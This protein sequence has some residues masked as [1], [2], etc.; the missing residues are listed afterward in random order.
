MEKKKKKGGV[1]VLGK[2]L[3]GVALFMVLIFVVILVVRIAN[4]S[5]VKAISIEG[6]YKELYLGNPEFSSVEYNITVYPETATNKN[7]VAITS[8]S[9]VATA[10]VSDGKIK[11]TAVGEGSC[12]ITVQ[13]LAKSSLIDSC[14]IVVKSIEVQ[15]LQF[16]DTKQDNKVINTVGLQKD[17][18]EHEIYFALD[19]V[20]ANMDKLT[21][22]YDDKCLERVSINYEKKCLVIVPKTEIVN[23]VTNV[24]IESNQNTEIG[25][26]PSK[27]VQLTVRLLERE[28]YLKFSFNYSL[29]KPF[30]D[31]H[32]GFVY[33]DPKAQRPADS[34]YIKPDICYDK[35]LTDIGVFKMED[36]EV[37]IDNELIFGFDSED[38]KVIYD[39]FTVQKIIDRNC[40][41]VTVTDEFTSGSHKLWFKHKYTGAEGHI[42]V[43]YA[44]QAKFTGSNQQLTLKT[45]YNYNANETKLGAIFAI[46]E[47]QGVYS[48]TNNSY[49]K[50]NTSFDVAVNYSIGEF[51]IVNGVNE[52]NGVTSFTNED[53]DVVKIIKDGKN[54]WLQAKAS[55]KT[56]NNV[57]NV[58]IG[59]TLKYWDDRF[60]A[61]FTSLAPRSFK[62]LIED[63][64]LVGSANRIDVTEK[65]EGNQYTITVTSSLKELVRGSSETGNPDTIVIDKKYFTKNDCSAIVS[66]EDIDAIYVSD[67]SYVD[68]APGS[69]T[70]KIYVKQGLESYKDVYIIHLQY[71]NLVMP[72]YL[73]IV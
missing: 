66:A 24:Y 64:S 4:K 26:V 54:M 29:N 25:V 58:T 48:V 16:V 10:T 44:D 12:R 55:H 32:N 36:Y 13:S 41:L 9:A 62:F 19:P 17:G 59:F 49:L 35:D 65:G 67:P 34:F 47:S 53:G 45:A 7:C 1:G 18:L 3:I 20:D 46:N 39:I 28:A 8:N 51:Y 37:Y 56:K 31:N 21:I 15:D 68:S 27:Y 40:Y 43:I 30:S 73:H 61:N 2:V 42:E 33:L 14:D 52:G 50:L 22:S 11:I 70:F 71:G 69:W 72:I 57:V 6:A 63:I 23:T 38:E 60:Y 5:I